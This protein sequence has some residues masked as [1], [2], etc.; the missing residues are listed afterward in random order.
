MGVTVLSETD[1]VSSLMEPEVE[2]RSRHGGHK[3]FR[4]HVLTLELTYS[5]ALQSAGTGFP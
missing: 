3:Q 1:V 2:R 5:R 4:G